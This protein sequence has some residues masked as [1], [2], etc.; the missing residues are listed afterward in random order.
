MAVHPLWDRGATVHVSSQQCPSYQTGQPQRSVNKCLHSTR[1]AGT[2]A[3]IIDTENLTGREATRSWLA[4]DEDGVLADCVVF[5]QAKLCR[6]PDYLDWV[7]ACIVPCAGVTAWTAMKG[8]RVG[9]SVL[10]QGRNPQSFFLR[11]IALT[12]GK[13]P[14]V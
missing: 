5:D 10:I 8:F 12:Q 13:V 4:A 2:L 3:P 7:Q 6:L 1:V 14:E 11:V 9:K